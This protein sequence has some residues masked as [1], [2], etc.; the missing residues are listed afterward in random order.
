MT[1]KQIAQDLKIPERTICFRLSTIV[2]DLRVNLKKAGVASTAV[3]TQSVLQ[4][5]LCS[6]YDVSA[7][8][9]EKIML[10]VRVSPPQANRSET[11]DSA[12]TSR[13]RRL[14]SV[15]VAACVSAVIGAGV[16]V[17]SEN[18]TKT[19]PITDVR[20]Q[21][22][23]K[24]IDRAKEPTIYKRWDFSEFEEAQD[25]NVTQGTWNHVPTGPKVSGRMR[26]EAQN[27]HATLPGLSIKHLPI[28]ITLRVR[29]LENRKDKYQGSSTSVQWEQ[30]KEAA[31]FK[32]ANY[33]LQNLLDQPLM[34][35][36]NLRFHITKDMITTW[37][38]PRI[39][40]VSY[41]L[42]LKDSALGIFNWGQ[43]EIDWIEISKIDPSAL[44]DLGRYR[45]AI[46]DIAPEKRFGT[47]PLPHFTSPSPGRKVY[48]Y[49]KRQTPPGNH[50]DL[51]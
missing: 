46:A 4:S 1:Q 21:D 11:A 35:W 25:F 19:D 49:F 5:A 38:G 41:A 12:L 15:V 2:E 42:P 22:F 33:D 18:G 17:F 28:M 40:S 8:L 6:S 47:I 32:N 9:T 37:K 36:F 50:V 31:H 20:A 43:N 51:K 7:A 45:K 27:F 48:L 30:T 29:V 24:P 3:C 10:S 44:P 13:P 16:L 26:I 39:T 14:T 34:V 23:V